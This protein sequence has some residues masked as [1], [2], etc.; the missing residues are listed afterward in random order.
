LDEA[1]KALKTHIQ[2]HKGRERGWEGGK[3]FAAASLYII[4]TTQELFIIFYFSPLL[5]LLTF[6]PPLLFSPDKNRM[7]DHTPNGR[8][9]GPRAPHPFE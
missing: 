6:P 5:A 8:I 1:V 9:V 3:R 2:I 7:E 4:L